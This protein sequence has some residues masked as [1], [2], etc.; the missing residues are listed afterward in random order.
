M[1]HGIL[2][3]VQVLCALGRHA[4]LEITCSMERT[5]GL[6]CPRFSASRQVGSSAGYMCNLVCSDPKIDWTMADRLPCQY[7]VLF[8]AAEVR[9]LMSKT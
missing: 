8:A 4:L 7:A 3:G 1:S 2:E 5:W 9:L 6:I